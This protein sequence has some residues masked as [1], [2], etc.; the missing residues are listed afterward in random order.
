MFGS[1]VVFAK[2]VS[3]E[4]KKTVWPTRKETV[5]TSI[6]VFILAFIAAIFF[7]LA[8]ISIEYVVNLILGS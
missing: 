1:V 5:V 8:D 4:I 6:M 3:Y 2:Q 7:L